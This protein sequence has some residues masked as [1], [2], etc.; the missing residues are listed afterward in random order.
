MVRLRDF[1]SV[2]DLVFLDGIDLGADVSN[3]LGFFNVT[4][5]GTT[6]GALNGL[7]LGT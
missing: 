7:S 2:I 6:H 5:I 3:D 1:C 4:V